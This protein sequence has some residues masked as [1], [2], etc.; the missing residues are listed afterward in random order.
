MDKEHVLVKEYLKNYS[1]VESNLRSFND[2]IDNKMQ[3]IVTELSADLPTEDFEIKLGKVKV[4]KPN[5]VESD[6]SVKFLTPAESRLRNLT[7]SAPISLD[8]SINY[9]G[10]TESAEV[11]L[12][13]IPIKNKSKVC[14]LYGM[15]EQ[16]L[17]DNYID[18]KDPGGYFLINGNER[19]MVMSE[20]LASN[21]PFIEWQKTKNRLMLRLFSQ[22]GAY[23][24]PVSLM[25][26]SDGILELT[27]S[28]FR[29]IPSIVLLKALGLNSDAEISQ[30]IGKQT[31]NLIVN[32]YEF[33]DINSQNDALM[34]IAEKTSLQGTTKEILDRVKQ[35]FDSYFM[36]HMVLDKNSRIEK[37]KTL[38]K[39]IKQYYVAK[40]SSKDTVTDKDHYAN[41]RVRL[42]GDLLSDL[43][44]VN[45]NILL[46]EIQHSLQKTFKRRKFY[47]IK[48]L[49][50]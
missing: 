27:F 12:G 47:S 7:Y 43:F 17:I 45:M 1:L 46:R 6:G 35:R 21:Q 18:P 5:I 10:Q 2:F 26:N 15:S 39:F 20:D 40:Q 24:I 22:R 11:Q 25:E 30:L 31:D 41:K 36:P 28:R 48:T 4:G 38:C 8:M 13:R 44:R 19:V 37:A 34:W 33:A 9:G 14:N 49:A 50:K 3:E 23:K 32:L 42:S 16:E 29:D